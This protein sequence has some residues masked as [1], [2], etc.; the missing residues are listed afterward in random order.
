MIRVMSCECSLSCVISSLRS[1]ETLWTDWMRCSE[2]STTR[3][4]AS[5]L[6]LVSAEAVEAAEALRAT[7]WTEVFIWFMAA[8]AS[9]RRCA[10]SAAPL[11]DCSICAES[12]MEEEDTTPPTFSS[13]SASF[14]MASVLVFASRLASSAFSMAACAT[15]DCSLAFFDSA[16]ARS[17]CPLSAAT[18]STSDL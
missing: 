18:I 13:L 11:S 9:V 15:L 10:A 5:A 1:S 4:P 2:R 8:A 12:S 17:I 14:I 16:W 7:S 6:L 3:A